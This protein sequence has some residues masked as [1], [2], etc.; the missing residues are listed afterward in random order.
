MYEDFEKMEKEFIMLFGNVKNDSNKITE[1]TSYYEKIKSRIC[2]INR[3]RNEPRKNEMGDKSSVM[4]C[5]IRTTG[6]EEEYK[7]MHINDE[8]QVNEILRTLQATNKKLLLHCCGSK[9]LS[10]QEFENCLTH[11]TLEIFRCEQA[12]K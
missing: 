8:E 1:M 5:L 2:D 10:Y 12:L 6:L 3:K 9:R 11:H 4:Q 7:K